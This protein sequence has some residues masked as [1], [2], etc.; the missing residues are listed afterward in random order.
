MNGKRARGQKK[1]TFHNI[2]RKNV[3]HLASESELCNS[4]IGE[5]VSVAFL[6]L[7]EVFRP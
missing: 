3:P 6:R 4:E 7:E 5:G 2:S 1:T